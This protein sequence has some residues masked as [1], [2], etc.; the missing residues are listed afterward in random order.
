MSSFQKPQ[1]YAYDVSKVDIPPSLLP[2][3]AVRPIPT[4]NKQVVVRNNT[5]TQ[6]A[7]GRMEFQL[8][9]SSLGF[10]KSGSV[11]IN[12]K[13]Y[14]D[15][16]ATNINFSG[17][18][19]TAAS[20]INRITLQVGGISAERQDFYWLLQNALLAHSS[21]ASYYQIDS[22]LTERPYGSVCASTPGAL[23][24]MP[25]TASA[26]INVCIPVNL[27]LLNS[28]HDFPLWA[29]SPGSMVIS[30]DL[31]SVS[32]AFSQAFG[33]TPLTG[34]KIDSAEL[35]YDL[36]ECAP[37]FIAS[38]KSK[39]MQGSVYTLPYIQVRAQSL[40]NDSTVSFNYGINCSSL[41][42]VLMFARATK[43]LVCATGASAWA[44]GAGKGSFTR[45][46]T[47]TYA[48]LFLD[49]QLI[50]SLNLDN[51]PTQYV[52]LNKALSKLNDTNV[53][54]C[55]DLTRSNYETD[56]YVGA[57]GVRGVDAA[58]FVFQGRPVSQI[59]LEVN[60]SGSTDGTYHSFVLFDSVL[61]ISGDGLVLPVQ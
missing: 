12:A 18:C 26:A 45:D 53:T 4:T 28:G 39:M 15:N 51:T 32:D 22:V 54:S 24:T 33:S 5:G 50:N 41:K 16:A 44:D 55:S 30:C 34:Y 14:G 35:I 29:V 21:S 59:Q 52:E 43:T 58:G 25:T 38:L 2:N 7:G 46:G 17:P 23:A 3:D 6:Q 19:S 13:V 42:A 47:Q 8:S 11:Y 31:N 20:L 40:A 49:G 56:F 1:S 61:N 9:S 60:K 48:R 57:I 37:E 10:V 27:S 36:V